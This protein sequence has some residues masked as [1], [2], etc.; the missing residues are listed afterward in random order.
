MRWF[1]SEAF[2]HNTFAE[3]PLAELFCFSWYDFR[4]TE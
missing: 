2:V 3:E 4:S 1:V